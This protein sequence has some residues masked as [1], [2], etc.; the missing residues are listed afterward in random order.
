[1][2]H[3]D[4]ILSWEELSPSEQVNVM[5]DKLAEEGL[6][7][8]IRLQKFINSVFPGENFTIKEGGHKIAG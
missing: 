6:A 4:E 1:M 8:A 5:A 7:E 3:L 2:G